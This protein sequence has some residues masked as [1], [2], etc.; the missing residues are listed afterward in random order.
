[1][2]K[3]GLQ[4]LL[5]DKVRGSR[6]SISKFVKLLKTHKTMIFH[7]DDVPGR[8][9]GQVHAVCSQMPAK[10]IIAM[11][12]NDHTKIGIDKLNRNHVSVVCPI[13]KRVKG[14]LMYCYKS[15]RIDEM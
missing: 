11:Q 6:K 3:E 14:R 4:Y 12:V 10:R 15:Y 1:M 13:V 9:T 7:K 5:A 8:E 2:N